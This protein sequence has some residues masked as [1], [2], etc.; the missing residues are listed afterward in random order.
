MTFAVLVLFAALS[1]LVVLGGGAIFSLLS[2][3]YPPALAP[4]V[5]GV[6]EMMN[7]PRLSGPILSGTEGLLAVGMCALARR[8]SRHRGA[9][10]RG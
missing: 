3:K 10:G 5:N 8:V 9:A 6:T 4:A 7:T 1:G 2:E